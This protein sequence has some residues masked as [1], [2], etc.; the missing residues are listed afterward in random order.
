MENIIA[1]KGESDS[2]DSESLN[3]CG[4]RTWI[5]NLHNLTIIATDENATF[6]VQKNCPRRL[7]PKIFAEIDKNNS[8]SSSVI[9]EK[10]QTMECT[11]MTEE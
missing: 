7:N 6:S 1:F 5:S 10:W 8:N 11:A 2:E 4:E 3:V 9:E